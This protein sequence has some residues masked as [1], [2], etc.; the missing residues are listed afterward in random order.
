[1]L[2]CDKK[3]MEEA[4][5]NL[6]GGLPTAAVLFYIWYVTNNTHAREREEWRSEL[7]AHTKTIQAITEQTNKLTY[8]I[9]NYVINNRATTDRIPHK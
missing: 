8:I 5:I 1:M 9:E 4:I 3:E 2:L 6:L 7:N